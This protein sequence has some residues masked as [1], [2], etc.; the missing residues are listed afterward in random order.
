MQRKQAVKTVFKKEDGFTMLELLL[1]LMIIAVMA[2]IIFPFTE[3]RLAEES[4]KEAI[5]QF[6]AAVYEAQLYAITNGVSVVVTFKNEGQ[7]YRIEE[8]TAAPVVIMSRKFPEGMH[9]IKGTGAGGSLGYL[10][11]IPSGIMSPTGW[12]SFQ[13]KTIGKVKITFQFE[14]GRMLLYAEG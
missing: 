4:E 13:T 12:I 7:E 11:F 10:V 8:N 14:L 3:K 1:V 9:K 2:M 5:E 6:M